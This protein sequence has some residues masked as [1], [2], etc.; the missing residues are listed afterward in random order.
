MVAD[1]LQVKH[2]E[3]VTTEVMHQAI[4]RF[5]EAMAENVQLVEFP[6][7]HQFTPGLYIREI[8]M[9]R[10]AVLTSRIHK[11]EHPFVVTKGVV[12]VWDGQHEWHRIVAPFKG[13]TKPGTRRILIVEEETVWTTYHV[14]DKTTPDEVVEDVTYVRNPEVMERARERLSR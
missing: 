2:E 4:D 5:E 11:Y 13:I 14:T 3:S 1:A 12:V 7:V 9:P 8:T 10:G 6:V